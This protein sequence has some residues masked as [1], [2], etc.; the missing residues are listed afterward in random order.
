MNHPLQQSPDEMA[1]DCMGTI[2]RACADMER[3]AMDGDYSGLKVHFDF[4]RIQMGRLDIIRRD[5][6]QKPR[7]L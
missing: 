5:I 3:C 4:V 7:E 2:A 1:R 6:R